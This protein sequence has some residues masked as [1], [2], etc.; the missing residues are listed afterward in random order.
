VAAALALRDR[1]QALLSN[2]LEFDLQVCACVCVCVHVC[3]CACV[4]V[5]V[6]ARVCVRVCACVSLETSMLGYINMCMCVCWRVGAR[7]GVHVS[8][9]VCVTLCVCVIEVYY[10]ASIVLAVV[11]VMPCPFSGRALPAHVLLSSPSPCKLR[12]TN[13]YNK[14]NTRIISHSSGVYLFQVH[15]LVVGR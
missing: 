3:V 9:Y 11:R 2:M 5:Y 7:T 8:M 14:H 10:C 13:A 1:G 12:C 6:C 4:C 15:V